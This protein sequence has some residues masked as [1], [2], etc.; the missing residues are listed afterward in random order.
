MLAS[1]DDDSVMFHDERS[2]RELGTIRINMTPVRL[3]DT[4]FQRYTPEVAVSVAEIV[5]PSPVHETMKKATTHCAKCVR[6]EINWADI[7]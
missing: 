6:L 4:T 5:N 3:G 1:L 2:F 7:C